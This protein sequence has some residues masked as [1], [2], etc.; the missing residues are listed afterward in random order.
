MII[1]TK[2]LMES[3]NACNIGPDFFTEMDLW[4]LDEKSVLDKMHE[5]NMHAERDWWL[6]VK[7][8][9]VGMEA[10]QYH[11]Y[12]NSDYF[13]LDEC[14]IILPSLE[15]ILV[16]TYE[17]ACE[18]ALQYFNEYVDS[19]SMNDVFVVNHV[20]VNE[21]EQT[22]TWTVVDLY[23]TE[24]L[25]NFIVFNHSTG[26]NSDHLTLEEAKAKIADLKSEWAATNRNIIKIEQVMRSIDGAEVW[27]RV[28][29]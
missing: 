5:A 29:W 15:V 23:T 8:S 18:R 14:K 2:E 22:T 25:D 28:R 16:D 19:M 10:I 13:T 6:S 1:L 3:I 9:A 20:T 27:R 24:L 7:K 21:E 26:L 17:L 4:G 12:P 11:C